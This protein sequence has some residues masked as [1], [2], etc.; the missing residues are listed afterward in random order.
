MPKPR[1]EKQIQAYHF[2]RNHAT[3]GEPFTVQDL[4]DATGW[5]PASARTYL[6]KQFEDY[7]RQD[8]QNYFVKTSFSHVSLENFL[9]IVTQNRRVI[10]QY[11][12]SVYSRVVVYEFLLPLTKEN[13]LR[14]SLDALFF[15]DTV[16]AR[17]KEI[18]VERLEEYL[19]RTSLDEA[20]YTNS[21][22][23]FVS[24]HFGGYSISHV[25]GRF[26]ADVLI[27]RDE[28]SERIL[29][30]E[31]Y[32]IDETTALVRFIVPCKASGS[33]FSSQGQPEQKPDEASI[34]AEIE[35]IRFLFFELF[36]EAIVAVIKNEE[37][38]WLLERADSERL[39]VWT[40]QS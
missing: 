13:F 36:V 7:L 15:R 18:G 10:S 6:R 8:E 24:D 29:S 40:K 3:N 34:E 2:L 21:V 35:A 38:I 17:L 19:P 39:Y 9:D 20:D 23:S 26:K 33:P 31:K 11:S 30:G 5:K 12:R 28:L 1:Q 22:V 37:E 14:D 27:S 4:M 32:L 25:Q 16:E